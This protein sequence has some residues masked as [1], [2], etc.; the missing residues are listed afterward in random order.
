M[1][2]PPQNSVLYFCYDSILAVSKRLNKPLKFD[3]DVRVDCKLS[4]NKL[5]TDFFEMIEL[6]MRPPVMGDH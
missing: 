5:F 2:C 6:I 4:I 1:I 3:I